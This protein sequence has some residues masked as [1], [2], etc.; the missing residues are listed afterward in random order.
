MMRA[1]NIVQYYFQCPWFCHARRGFQQHRQKYDE[2]EEPVRPNEMT[3][4][5]THKRRTSY[6]SGPACEIFCNWRTPARIDLVKPSISR[7]LPPLSPNPALSSSSVIADRYWR[8]HRTSSTVIPF[9]ISSSCFPPYPHSIA[10]SALT[11]LTK[12]LDCCR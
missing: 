3:K 7:S 12:S 4:P 2:E 5:E 6:R 10:P 11:P 1:D 9:L 8:S